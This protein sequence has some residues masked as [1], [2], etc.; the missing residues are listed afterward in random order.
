MPGLHSV[1]PIDVELAQSLDP[2]QQTQRG[3]RD[4]I[5]IGVHGGFVDAEDFE[6]WR[7]SIVIPLFER[8]AKLSAP[9]IDMAIGMLW[10]DQ[11]YV[12]L[13]APFRSSRRFVWAAPYHTARVEMF[14]GNYDF[15]MIVVFLII[16]FLIFF[17]TP[18]CFFFLFNDLSS[19]FM[20]WSFQLFNSL[21]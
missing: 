19:I 18:R 7:T 13:K 11:S 3:G 17:F 10:P 5:N 6:R 8:R 12:S 1:P 16:Y 2:F 15:K 14:T 20:M 21:F 9:A 4:V